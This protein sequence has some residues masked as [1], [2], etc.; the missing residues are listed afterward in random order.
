MHL[1]LSDI[2]FSNF[3]LEEIPFIDLFVVIITCVMSYYVVLAF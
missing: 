3:F 1:F 2:F